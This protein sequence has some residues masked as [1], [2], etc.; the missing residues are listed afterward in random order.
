MKCFYIVKKTFC[1]LGEPEITCVL[2]YLFL[3]ITPQPGQKEDE[4][5]QRPE[6]RDE[7]LSDTKTKLGTSGPAKSKTLEVMDE[8]GKDTHT[9]IFLR[10]N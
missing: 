6:V 2:S 7:D 1:R 3:F 4:L 5:M 9:P 8:C 10:R